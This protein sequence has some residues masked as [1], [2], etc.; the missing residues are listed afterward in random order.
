MRTLSR[1]RVWMAMPL[2]VLAFVAVAGC[3]SGD[4]GNNAAASTLGGLSAAQLGAIGSVQGEG[5]HATGVGKV[6]ATPDLALLSLGVEASAETVSEARETTSKA[7]NAVIASLKSQ[8]LRENTDIQTAS[9]NIQPEYTYEEVI[10]PRESGGT[11]RRSV[12]RLVGYRVTNTLTVK[13]RDLD[14]IGPVIDGAVLGGGDAIRVNSVQFTVE[15]NTAL[16]D[17]AR[18]LAL[19]DAVRKADVYAQELGVGRGKLQFVAET[20]TPSFSGGNVV[21]AFA[22]ASAAP[23]PILAGELEVVVRVQTVFAIQ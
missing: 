17:Q 22:E 18:L 23:T 21:R 6:T 4:G 19:R 3:T 10:S 9:F 15:D 12:Q 20:S 2:A 11:V 7:I 8:G 14:S 13:V 16:E 1:W 5:I